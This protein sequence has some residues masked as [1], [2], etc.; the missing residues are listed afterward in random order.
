MSSGFLVIDI[1]A[2]ALMS[3]STVLEEKKIFQSADFRA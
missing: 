1:L 3:I 2:C